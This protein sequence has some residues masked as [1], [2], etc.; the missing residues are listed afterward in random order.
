[1]KMKWLMKRDGGEEGKSWGD[2]EVKG[3]NHF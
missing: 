2:E 1:M 3:E